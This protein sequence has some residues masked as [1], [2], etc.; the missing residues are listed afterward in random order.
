MTNIKSGG[1]VSLNLHLNEDSDGF[2]LSSDQE[3]IL[4]TAI[5]NTIVVTGG[6]RSGAMDRKLTVGFE[7]A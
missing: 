2:M 3:H 1:E 4:L 6:P 5:R 7:V